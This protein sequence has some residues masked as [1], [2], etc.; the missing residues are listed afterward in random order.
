MHISVLI[1]NGSKT[2]GTVEVN[3]GHIAA[4]YIELILD[5]FDKGGRST[6]IIN[7]DEGEAVAGAMTLAVKHARSLKKHRTA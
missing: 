3:Q 6:I 4:D 7:A 5:P 1:K 2:I